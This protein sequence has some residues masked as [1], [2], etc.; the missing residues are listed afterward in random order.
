MYKRLRYFTGLFFLFVSLSLNSFA[1]KASIQGKVMDKTD[2]S[3]LEGANVV[4]LP[5]NFGTATRAGGEYKLK[6]LK[7]GNYTLAV[8]FVGYKTWKK[9]LTLKDGDNL[10]MDI[11]L[12]KGPVVLSATEIEVKS[13]TPFAH[14]KTKLLQQLIEQEATKDIGD[15]LRSVPNVSGIKKGGTNIDPVIRGFKF[16]QLNVHMDGGIRIEG[17]CPNRMDPTSAHVEMEDIDN[18]EIIKGPYVLRYGPAFGGIINLVTKKPRPSETGK[19]EIHVRGLKGYESNWDGDKEHLQVYGGT[20]SI[21]FSLSGSQ[22]RYG[23]YEDG[24]GNT[25]PSSF[26]KWNQSVEV[27]LRPL[28]NHEILLSFNESHGRNVK[29][30]A[31]PMD[32]RKDDTRVMAFDYTAKKV[33]DK[34]EDIKVKVYRSHVYHEMDNKEKPFGDTVAAVSI[35]D[36]TVWGGRAEIGLKP[37][38]AT[39][40]FIGT[41]FEVTSKDGD[42]TKNFYEMPPNTMGMP[43]KVEELWSD[44]RIQNNGFFVEYSGNY[45]TWNFI[46]AARFDIN[47]GTTANMDIYKFVMGKPDTVQQT[48]TDVESKYNNFSFSLG[49]NKQLNEKTEIG[50]GLGRGVRSPNMLERYIRL[51]PVGFDKYDYLGDPLLKPEKNHQADLYVNF[52]DDKIGTFNL[53]GF[54]SYVIDY[55]TAK[56]LPPSEILPNTASVLGV[57]Q[58]VN[59][60]EPVSFTGFEFTYASPSQ[61][62]LQGQVVASYTM[63]TF[64]GIYDK[65]IKITNDPVNEIPPFEANLL[66]RYSLFN[67]K[68][69]PRLNIR[70]VGAQNRVSTAFDEQAT[71]AFT[72]ADFGLVYNHNKF[73]KV[74]GGINNIFDKAYYEHLNRRILGSSTSLYEPGRIFYINMI[75]N[76]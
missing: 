17:G 21:Y 25:L 74:T 42:R 62:K 8:S 61:Y 26:H 3:P 20:K 7:K 16:D 73:L 64:S 30:P 18:I 5:N 53:N 57:K 13:Q 50:L 38:L 10:N 59:A 22:L 68:L 33:S 65:L 23:N 34:I 49:L 9:E 11:S 2:N 70:Y 52:E 1:Q 24:N 47:S 44:S 14:G 39:H 72:L 32:E 58:F 4:L 67:N 51:L 6:K 15:F 41:D 29:F 66:L 46:A 37:T 60:P 45:E 63:G 76:I 75:V 43:V 19:F 55:I 54:Y 36:P 56:Q 31:L 69:I 27:G 71:P 35:I 12:E 48:V 28:E 40:I